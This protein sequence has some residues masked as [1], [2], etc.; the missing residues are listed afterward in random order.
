MTF[1][2]TFQ[3]ILLDRK[4][5]KNIGSLA[6]FNKENQNQIAEKN[7]D[8]IKDFKT[9]KISKDLNEIPSLNVDLLLHNDSIGENTRKEL[10]YIKEELIH[11]Y[12]ILSRRRTDCE[13]R[14]S[15]LQDNRFTTHGSKFFQANLEQQVHQQ[16]LLGITLDIEESNIEIEKL[17]YQYKKIE[18]K[19]FNLSINKKQNTLLDKEKNDSNSDVFV[20][21]KETDDIFLNEKELQLLSI[22]IRKKLSQLKEQ[23]MNAENEAKELLEWSKIK[24]EEFSLA[25]LNNEAFDPQDQNYGQ[26]IHLAKRFFQNYINAHTTN[27]DATTSDILNIDGLCLTALNIGMKNNLLDKMFEGFTEKQIQFIFN[28]IYGKNIQ[29]I[30]NEN[31]NDMMISS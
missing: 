17:I 29:L 6:V 13:K 8:L 23:K 4:N 16:N 10:S 3:Q 28:G 31:S 18:N 5:E 19:L 1:D 27:A 24:E 15:V 22:K 26:F 20:F 9:Q 2:K 30:K 25:L 7:K 12:N 21:D 11:G 14:I